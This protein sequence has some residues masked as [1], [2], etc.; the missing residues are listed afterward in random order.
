MS[1]RAAQTLSQ[2]RS[3]KM[4]H[5]RVEETLPR[6]FR[7][8]IR[9]TRRHDMPNQNRKCDVK[10]AGRRSSQSMSS[11]QPGF[12]YFCRFSSAP[13]RKRALWEF[14]HAEGR[15][16]YYSHTHVSV[17][18]R[19]VRPRGPICQEPPQVLKCKICHIYFTY[20]GFPNEG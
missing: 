1:V 18:P 12:L 20:R 14:F 9:V 5:G 17:Q 11:E 6:S 3:S 4:A 7:H 16:F 8:L 19:T 13:V 15:G 10:T 2:S